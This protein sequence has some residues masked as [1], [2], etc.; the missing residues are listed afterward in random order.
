MRRRRGRHC[1]QN[2][3]ANIVHHRQ[4]PRRICAHS[5]SSPPLPPISTTTP[6]RL[7]IRQ[8]LRAYGGG[9]HLRQSGTV[10]HG[11]AGGLRPPAAALLPANGRVSD[12]LQCRV[13]VLVRERHVQMV[14][15]D[16]APLSGRAHD[17][18][19]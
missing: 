17:L 15:G 10:G 12:L 1:R 18:S 4:F 6:L 8:L 5:V 3:H 19:R 7:Q 14:S 9:R 16:Q 11:R 2:L 13:T